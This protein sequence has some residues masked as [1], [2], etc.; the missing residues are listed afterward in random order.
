MVRI[1]FAD[2]MSGIK[3]TPIVNFRNNRRFHNFTFPYII[4][5]IFI[6][7]PIGTKHYFWLFYTLVSTYFN[8]YE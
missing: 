4:Y 5:H 7:S 2:D 8:N 3:P 1:V 6:I